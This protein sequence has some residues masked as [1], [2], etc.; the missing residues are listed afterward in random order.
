MGPV[1][2]LANDKITKSRNLGIGPY[3]TRLDLLMGTY[4]S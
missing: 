4:G 1:W 3:E 2:H